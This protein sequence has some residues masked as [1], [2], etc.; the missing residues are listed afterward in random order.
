VSGTEIALNAGAAH[1]AARVLR[2]RPNDRI[3]LFNGTF[4]VIISMKFVEKE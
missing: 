4:N 1:H 3:R 2:L